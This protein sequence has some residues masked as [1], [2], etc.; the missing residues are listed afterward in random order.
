MNDK[1]LEKNFKFFSQ[2]ANFK[3]LDKYK[4]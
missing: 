1:R 4:N 2:Y 3:E